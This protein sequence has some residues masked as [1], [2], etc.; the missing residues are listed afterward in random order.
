[1][2]AIN[3]GGLGLKLLQKMGYKGG[4]LGKEGT[5]ISQALEAKQRAALEGLGM[6]KEHK[7]EVEA[8]E[9]EAADKKKKPAKKKKDFN[10][11]VDIGD[12]DKPRKAKKVYKTAEEIRLEA[13][14]QGGAGGGGAR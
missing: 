6:R 10:W 14:E 13:E 1:V 2:Q 11:K 3:A 9:K 8:K 4:G 12:I 5:G 7:L